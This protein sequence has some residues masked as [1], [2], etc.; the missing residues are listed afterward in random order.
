MNRGLFMFEQ[1]GVSAGIDNLIPDANS[2]PETPPTGGTPEPE[3]TPDPAWFS[4]MPKETRDNYRDAL[5][6]YKSISDLADA[7]M[8]GKKDLEG[9]IRI[10]TKDSSEEEQKKFFN[11]LGMPE[12]MDEYEFPDG[13]YASLGVDVEKLR[14]VFRKAA[15]QSALTKKQAHNLWIKEMAMTKVMQGHREAEQQAIEKSFEPTYHKLLEAEYPV[16]AERTKAM[17]GEVEL[18]QKFLTDTGLGKLFKD[19][20]IIYDAN[21]MHSI[22]QYVKKHTGSFVDGVGDS[23]KKPAGMMGNYSEEFMKRAGK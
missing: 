13:D 17:K 20:N 9:S 22:S 12:S 15:W 4:Q 5:K 19:K 18:V 14:D 16:E 8:K 3:V 6:G 1:E 11:T 2:T 23:G 10:P 7:Y 21:A